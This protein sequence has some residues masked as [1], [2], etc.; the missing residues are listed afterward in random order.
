MRLILIDNHS[1][2]IWAD[3]ADLPGFDDSITDHETAALA[4]ARGIDAH[5]GCHNPRSYAFAWSNRDTGTGYHVYRADVR[6]S[7]A[8]PV[9]HDGQDQD[10]IDTVMRDCEYVGYVAVREDAE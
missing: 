9:V 1:G 6:G 8:V 10:T 7:E 2:Y 5:V 3:T 4:A